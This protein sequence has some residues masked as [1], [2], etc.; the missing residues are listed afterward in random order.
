MFLRYHDISADKRIDLQSER[1]TGSAP[2]SEPVTL[3]VSGK[4]QR[5]PFSM[6][7]TAEPLHKLLEKTMPYH[8]EDVITAAGI[9]ARAEGNFFLPAGPII[10]RLQST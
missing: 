4:L 1:I 5:Q 7:L 2:I 8:F 9:G 6:R 3:A 10:W